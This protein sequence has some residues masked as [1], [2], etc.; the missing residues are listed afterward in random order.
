M[1]LS[2]YGKNNWFFQKAP[3]NQNVSID[4]YRFFS[5]DSTH[6][7]RVKAIYTARESGH[8]PRGQNNDFTRCPTHSRSGRISVRHNRLSVYR[9]CGSGQCHRTDPSWRQQS[10]RRS[11]YLSIDQRLLPQNDFLSKSLRYVASPSSFH[12]RKCR[13][14]RY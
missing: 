7:I 14:D 3:D 10:K 12:L 1:H 9:R 8:C 4:D 13:V 6:S 5:A 11:N 2:D